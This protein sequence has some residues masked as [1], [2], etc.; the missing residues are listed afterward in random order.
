M[1]PI[2]EFHLMSP[3]ST[4]AF[5]PTATWENLRFRAAMLRRLREFFDSRGFL[6]VET[7][8]LSADTVVDRHLD[9]FCVENSG[10]RPVVSGQCE[11]ASSQHSSAASPH[12]NPL[13]K[14]EGT[15][16][17]RLWLQTSPEFAMKRMLAAGAGRIYQVARVFR[18]DEIGP[19]HNPE[20][21]L[22]EWYQPG[23]GLDEGMQLTAD[24]CEALLSIPHTP[25]AEIGTR[26][27]PATLAAERISYGEAFERYVGIDPHRADGAALLAAAKKLGVEA[28]RV[29]RWKTATA[30]SICFWSSGFNLA[31][32]LGGRR[33][34]TIIR[35]ARRRWPASDRAIRR[36]PSGSSYTCPAL[37]WPTGITNCSIRR[38]FGRETPRRIVVGLP[39]ES[40]PCPGKAACWRR[41]RPA[42]L[43]RWAWPWG[44]TAW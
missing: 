24:L 19:L 33:S 35:P 3:V 2:S 43:P 44:S 34:C 26:R 10:Q 39:T 4:N 21:T 37:N 23:E 31:W 22:V 15:T 41:W 13:P 8:I 20:F 40:R 12:P 38:C 7:P 27:V 5:R 42:C 11:A 28:P 18:Q 36:S 16:G 32:A 17:S 29:C 1:R 9:P 25:C 6:E 14:G 30:G